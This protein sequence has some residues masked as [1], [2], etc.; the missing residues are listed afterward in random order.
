[1][2]GWVGY[3]V[4]LG[5]LLLAAPLIAWVG[6]RHGRSLKGGAGLAFIMLGFG[7]VI[8]PPS[9]HLIEAV[10]G[11]EQEGET[12]GEPKDATSGC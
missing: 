12:T 2:Q 4:A 3:L 11:E 5:A 7:H 1:M 9:R 8:D 10:E 6:R